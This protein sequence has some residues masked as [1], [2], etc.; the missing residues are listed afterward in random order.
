MLYLVRYFA[1]GSGEFQSGDDDAG[2]QGGST[3][4]EGKQGYD[5][6]K[7]GVAQGGSCDNDHATDQD[8]D[9]SIDDQHGIADHFV[10]EEQAGELDLYFVN[11]LGAES[12]GRFCIT[13]SITQGF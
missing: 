13:A 9:G 11:A 7:C 5:G 12:C 1:F 2:E 3:D 10:T 4:E 8:Q 6:D